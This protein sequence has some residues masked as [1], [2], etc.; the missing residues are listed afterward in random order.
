MAKRFKSQIP[1]GMNEGSGKSVMKFP[2]FESA[3]FFGIV[4]ETDCCVA[5]TVCT[6][7]A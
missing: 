3:V 4:T 1:E 6:C 2:M 5:G 7:S